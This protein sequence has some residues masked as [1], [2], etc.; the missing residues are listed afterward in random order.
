MSVLRVL[1]AEDNLDIAE[2]IGDFLALNGHQ[3]DYAY[4]GLMAVSLVESQVFDVIVMDL[5]MPRLDGLQATGKIRTMVNG[6]VPI[7]MLTAK[8]TLDEKLIGFAAGADDYIVKPFDMPELYARI[9]AQARK[10]QKNYHHLLSVEGISLDQKQQSASIDNQ[11]L[12]LNPTTFKIMWQLTKA[13]P[14]RVSKQV[15]EFALWGDLRPEKD[16]LRSHIYNLRKSLN[17]CTG[18]VTVVGIHGQGYQL[19]ITTVQRID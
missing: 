8:D 9:Q 2:N 13:F 3:V 4:D 19:N 14:D 10:A 17:R 11:A 5:M 15:L 16:I 1:I 6:D 12:V 18:H 7:L